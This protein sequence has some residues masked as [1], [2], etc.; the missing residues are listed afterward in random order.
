MIIRLRENGETTILM[1]HL[2]WVSR[3][4]HP[5]ITTVVSW[6]R[7]GILG[8]HTPALNQYWQLVP[9]SIPNKCISCSEDCVLA[10]TLTDSMSPGMAVT[11]MIILDLVSFPVMLISLYLGTFSSRNK[12]GSGQVELLGIE[13]SMIKYSEATSTWQIEEVAK[14]TTAISEATFSSF[15]LGSHNWTI[16]NDNKTCSTKGESYSRR[17][18]LTGC[19]VGNFTCDDGQCIR[20]CRLDIW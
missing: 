11:I 8:C 18:K 15:A 16:A 2:S 20:R 12:K 1:K 19:L 13:T 6:H 4:Q 7:Y 5:W 3:L 9:V 14:N 10:H 17:L